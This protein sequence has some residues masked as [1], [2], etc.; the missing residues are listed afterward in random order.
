MNVH[1]KAV[2]ERGV[3]QEDQVAGSMKVE[4]LVRPCLKVRIATSTSAV[5]RDTQEKATN[6]I[7]NTTIMLKHERICRRK[8]LASL[9]QNSVGRGIS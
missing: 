6:W 4:L 7:E 1:A 8:K 3:V 9:L 2:A 5:R